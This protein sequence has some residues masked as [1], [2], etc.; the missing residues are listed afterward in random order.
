MNPNTLPRGKLAH[1]KVAAEAIDTH[2][3]FS[4]NKAT[5]A[6]DTEAGPRTQTAW[7]TDIKMASG[8]SSGLRH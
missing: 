4:G 7:A 5:W 1:G 8:G 3:T 6:I 2:K